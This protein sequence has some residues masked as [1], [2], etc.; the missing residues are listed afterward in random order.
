MGCVL[1]FPRPKIE[2]LRIGRLSQLCVDGG[3]T[4]FVELVGGTRFELLEWCHPK[5]VRWSRTGRD[6][7]GRSIPGHRRF[8][9]S[10]LDTVL[11]KPY[12]VLLRESDHNP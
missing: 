4:D 1:R 5:S 7:S 3:G 12:I 2:A 10:P 9:V 8:V 11:G 6:K